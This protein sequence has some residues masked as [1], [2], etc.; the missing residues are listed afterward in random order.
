[1]RAA[2]P[3]LIFYP[4]RH[5]PITL[6]PFAQAL[7]S[8]ALTYIY[9]HT[10]TL[11][12][13]QMIQRTFRNLCSHCTHSIIFISSN[14]SCLVLIIVENSE[15]RRFRHRHD[16]M[17]HIYVFGNRKAG[18]ASI[19]KINSNAVKK[20]EIVAIRKEVAQHKYMEKSIDQLLS[21]RTL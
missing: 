6:D 3:T 8:T 21:T 11:P 1:M 17:L 13:C 16:D 14:T 9:S 5:K 4:H 20:Y 2:N 7:I 18:F 19:T 12:L 15:L 10:Y